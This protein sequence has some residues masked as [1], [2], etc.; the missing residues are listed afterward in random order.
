MAQQVRPALV[1]IVLFTLITGLLY[2]FVVTGIAQLA[3]SHQANGSLIE[4]D[5]HVIGSELIGQTFTSDRYFHGRPSAAGDGYDAASSS[6]SNLGPT[7]RALIDRIRADVARLR[8]ENPGAAVP[9]DLVTASGSGL[10]PHISLPAALF[11]V[12]RVANA[13]GLSEERVRML[14]EEQTEGRTFGLL[15]EP[16]VNVLRLNLA[17]DRMAKDE[18]R[19]AV[20]EDG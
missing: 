3:F 2:P 17:L 12:A 7:S 10:D 9:I 18:A 1:L 13:R 5:G 15:G 16:R 11:Q 20:D 19:P 6:G 14:V 4:R 8:A